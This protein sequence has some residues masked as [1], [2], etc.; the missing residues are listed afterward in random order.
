LMKMVRLVFVTSL[1]GISTGSA[2]SQVVSMA[3]HPIS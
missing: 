1:P 2:M 3:A